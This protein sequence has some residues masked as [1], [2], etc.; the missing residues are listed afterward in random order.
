MNATEANPYF[1]EGLLSYGKSQMDCNQKIYYDEHIS[2]PCSSFPL[3]KADK[4]LSR[5][6]VEDPTIGGP[7]RLW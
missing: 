4:F 6:R 5:R 3:L 1:S 7:S 2:S